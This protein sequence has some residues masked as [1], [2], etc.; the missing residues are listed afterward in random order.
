MTTRDSARSSG[1][2]RRDVLK[3]GGAAGVGAA[4]GLGLAGATLIVPDAATAAPRSQE[5]PAAPGT[6]RKVIFVNHDNNPFFVPVRIGLENFAALAGWE[7]P[8]FT[9]PPTGDTVA[10]VELQRQA[11][12]ALIQNGIILLGADIQTVPI[13]QGA[14]I[15]LAVL[16]DVAIRR[17][18]GL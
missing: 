9:G 13:A 12:A 18:Q 4:A 14:V 1:L 11:I 6:P 7:Q 10:T 8:Q 15:I 5:A 2:S 3:R 17:R 16:L